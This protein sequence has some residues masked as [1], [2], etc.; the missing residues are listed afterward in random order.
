MLL[1]LKA[2]LL[3]RQLSQR[4]VSRLSNVPENRLSSILNGWVHATADERR[5]LANVLKESEDVL[6]NRGTSIEIRSAR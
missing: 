1:G 5:K 2:V 4:A 6:F 3:Q